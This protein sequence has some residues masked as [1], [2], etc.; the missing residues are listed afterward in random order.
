[1]TSLDTLKKKLKDGRTA[2]FNPD[3]EIL[4]IHDPSGGGGGSMF[5]PSRARDYFDEL[6]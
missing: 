5:K 6:K 1:M 3:S 2:Y 4:V